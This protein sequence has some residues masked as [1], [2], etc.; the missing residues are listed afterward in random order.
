MLFKLP[1]SDP[2]LEWASAWEDDGEDITINVVAK[3]G[4]SEYK[5]VYTPQCTIEEYTIQNE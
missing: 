4:L 2:L 1:E 3:V 5:G